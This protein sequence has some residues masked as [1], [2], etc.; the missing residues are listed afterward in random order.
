[1]HLNEDHINNLNA[2]SLGRISD[3]CVV[4]NDLPDLN[5]PLCAETMPT[6]KR[7]YKHLGHHFE[8]CALHTLPLHVLGSE[9]DDEL[10][11]G[12]PYGRGTAD[13]AVSSFEPSGSRDP[14]D[15][16]PGSL[17]TD[18]S[19]SDSSF[20][21]SKGT[22]PTAVSSPRRLSITTTDSMTD[23]FTCESCSKRFSREGDLKRHVLYSHDPS[24][25][26]YRCSEC[27]FDDFRLDKVQGHCR[28]L[29]GRQRG[30]EQ[31][32]KET[33]RPSTVIRRRAPN[34]SPRKL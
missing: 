7:W 22:A 17:N 27:G 33:G 10:D 25:L 19:D 13:G 14:N 2:T 20:E 8:R 23:S 24:A 3:A 6:S 5:C 9:S 12:D 30:Q 11:V 21:I 26:F 28:K 18:Q 29:H 34:K 32:S 4:T 31:F 1:M 16:Q 15:P